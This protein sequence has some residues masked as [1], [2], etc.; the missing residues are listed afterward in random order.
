MDCI[1]K[2]LNDIKEINKEAKRKIKESFPMPEPGT[3]YVGKDF[4]WKSKPVF[5]DY[6]KK[7]RKRKIVETILG[8]ATVI[9]VG[10]CI[11]I[12]MLSF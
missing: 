9:I 11:V 10:G 3:I 5:I 6:N 8:F 2:C 1:E 4:N 12:L 7:S